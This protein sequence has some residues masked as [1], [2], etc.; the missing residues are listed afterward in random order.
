MYARMK[1]FDQKLKLIHLVI[2]NEFLIM[3]FFIFFIYLGHFYRF[4]RIFSNL[5]RE[6]HTHKKL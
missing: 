2:I 4:L 1:F 3:Y 6:F 5:I